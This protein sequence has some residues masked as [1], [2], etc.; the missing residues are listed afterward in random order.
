MLE[1]QTEYVRAR[2]SP[3]V[4]DKAEAIFDKLGLGHTEAIRLFY[5]QVLLNH[6]LPF[7]VNVPNREA[8]QALR[9]AKLRKGLKRYK[10][11]RQL[12]DKYR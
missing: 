12:F 8:V 11:A 3:S 10:T 5:Q 9:Q 2:I 6:G 7:N 1:N 4:K